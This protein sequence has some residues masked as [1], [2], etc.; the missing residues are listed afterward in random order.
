MRSFL[1]CLWHIAKAQQ[2]LVSLLRT[3]KGGA[4]KE[5]EANPSMGHI[6]EVLGGTMNPCMGV[7]KVLI[8]GTPRMWL[9]KK[10]GSQAVTQCPAR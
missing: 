7:V 10:S 8:P 6:L 9:W 1:E 3:H 5:R 4:C 2:L